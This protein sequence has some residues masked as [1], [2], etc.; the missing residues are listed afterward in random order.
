M[1]VSFESGELIAEVKE[2]IAEFGPAHKVLVWVRRYPEYNTSFIV[3]YDFI[4][5]ET[6]LHLAN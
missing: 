4:V 6:L 1:K 3:N 2:D 5:A